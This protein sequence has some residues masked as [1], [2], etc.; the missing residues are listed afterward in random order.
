MVVGPSNYTAKCQGQVLNSAYQNGWVGFWFL[1]HDGSVFTFSGMDGENP[2][3]DS[4]VN[5]LDEMIVNRGGGMDHSKAVPVKGK[6]IYTNPYLGQPANVSCSGTFKK[7]QRFS[8]IFVSDGNP[9]N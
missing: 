7:G 8:A 2:T 1:L 9:P 3:E 4:D 5:V 6:C